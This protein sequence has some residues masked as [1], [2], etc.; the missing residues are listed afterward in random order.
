MTFERRMR[1]LVVV[2]AALGG[3][4]VLLGLVPSMQMSGHRSLA[5]TL[6]GFLICII[7]FATAYGATLYKEPTKL[8]AIAWPIAS[9]GVY[10]FTMIVASQA[11]PGT[12][13]VW[14]AKASWNLIYAMLATT[15]FAIPV[16]LLGD[17]GKRTDDPT[18]RVVS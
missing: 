8:R 9:V 17:R 2:A 3:A 18:A 16:A 11:D 6:D 15:A 1:R 13:V 4:A 5:P 10:V 14:T 7:G 12:P